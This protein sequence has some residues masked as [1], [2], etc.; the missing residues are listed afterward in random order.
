MDQRSRG[1][2]CEAAELALESPFGDLADAFVDLARALGNRLRSHMAKSAVAVGAIGFLA[3][4]VTRR[5]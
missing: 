2:S 3:A 4:S 5:T 1:L